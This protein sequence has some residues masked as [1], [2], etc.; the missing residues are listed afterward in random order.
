MLFLLVAILFVMAVLT[1]AG[2]LLEDLLEG[3]RMRVPWH[4]NRWSSHHRPS[5]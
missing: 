3:M 2:P 5:R 4:R 1:V